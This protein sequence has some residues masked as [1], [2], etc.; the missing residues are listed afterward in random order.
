MRYR[1]L[2]QQERAAHVHRER[3]V[4]LV[5]RVV[6]DRRDR[7]GD[8]RVGDHHVKPPELADSGVHGGLHLRRVCDVGHPPGCPVA[9][10]GRA[11]LQ[12]WFG[13]SGQENAGTLGG[14]RA[15]G[16]HPDAA[17]A[18]GYDGGLAL[19]SAHEAIVLERV[20]RS[21]PSPV[22]D[23]N[24][25][26]TCAFASVLGGSHR[27]P[28]RGAGSL[29]SLSYPPSSQAWSRS[30]APTR[31]TSCGARWLPAGTASPSW[32]CWHGAGAAPISRSG[33]RSAVR[34]WCRW[35]GWRPG[36]SSSL[37][38]GWWRGPPGHWSTW[39]P[40][41][42][43]PPNSR[44]PPTRTPTTPTCRSWRCS[45]CPGRCTAPGC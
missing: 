1:V 25:S 2:A 17:L 16:R 6:G 15:S 35:P 3:L 8:P 33:C 31:C 5:L 13:D 32:R 14:E 9:E 24:I 28:C 34:C 38:S 21:E 19:K 20:R 42:R 27:Q 7:A 40:R 45:G 41:T 18:A 43:V 26:L 37:R 29:V 44:A 23:G 10:L 22:G 12:V 30:S 36:H 11:G 39:A 4:E